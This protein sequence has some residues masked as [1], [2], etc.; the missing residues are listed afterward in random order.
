MYVHLSLLIHQ[1][2][3]L[4][5]QRMWRLVWCSPPGGESR[6]AP[7]PGDRRLGPLF[8]MSYP[9]LAQQWRAPRNMVSDNVWSDWYGV[10]IQSVGAVQ[11]DEF[12]VIGDPSSDRFAVLY[13]RGDHLAGAF[14]VGLPAL[15]IKARRAINQR[16][17]WHDAVA[18]AK[19]LLTH[20]PT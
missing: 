10:R 3:Q 12:H 19:D 1:M 2:N 14:T 20:Q 17:P 15:L 8:V 9:V 7:P 13:R 16:L 5:L 18:A 11:A 4:V 6:A